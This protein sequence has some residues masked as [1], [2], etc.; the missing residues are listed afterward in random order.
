MA[1]EP[2]AR[3][4]DAGRHGLPRSLPGVAGGGA[5]DLQ[6]HQV[7]GFHTDDHGPVSGLGRGPGPA[8]FGLGPGIEPFDAASWMS[9]G[10]TLYVI[11]SGEVATSTALFRAVVEK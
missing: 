9:S 11:S 1:V 2:A 5:R 10:G 8:G 7:R 3:G 4:P 6:G